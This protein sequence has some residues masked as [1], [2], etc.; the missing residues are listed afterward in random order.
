MSF[1]VIEIRT[2]RKPTCDLQLVFR[3]PT[4]IISEIERLIDQNFPFLS[5]I[6]PPP[7]SRLT[8][9]QGEFPWDLWHESWNRETGVPG[10]PGGDKRIM[11]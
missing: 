10:L 1:K 3:C 6:L 2:N 7:Q 9:S 4:F 8:Q 5:A 11:L